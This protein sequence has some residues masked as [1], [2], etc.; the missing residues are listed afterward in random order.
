VTN[1]FHYGTPAEGDHF[2]GRTDELAALVGRMVDGIN[3]VV[4]SPRRYG[5]TSL[6]HAA[7]AR[8]ARRRP[9]GAAL[10]V[11]VLRATSLAALAGM[12][13]AGA[14]RL[15]GARWHRLRQAVPEFARRLRVQPAISFDPAGQP[16]FGFDAGLTALDA[17]AVIAD[18]YAL[19]AEEVERRPAALVLDEFQAVTRLGTGMPDVFKALADEHPSVSLV[20]AGSK[21]HL[22]EALVIEAHAPLYGMAQ[23]LT[24]GPLPEAEMIGFLRERAASGAR[25]F[26]EGAA[27]YL[28]DVAGPVPNDIQ[29]LAY[30][31]YA[32]ADR[33]IE[34]AS[35]DAAMARAVEHEAVLFAEHLGRLSPGQAR[36]MV[37]LASGP[38]A[39]PFGA[40]FAR[41]VGLASASSVRKA[42]QPLLA[43]E[44]VVEGPAGLAV[45]DPFFAAW[46]RGAP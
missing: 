31:A 26:A 22:M 35:V 9:A 39:E 40:A 1:P 20:L 10:E 28:V 43:E 18:V 33:H 36:V 46:L 12:L 2:T 45:A 34:V 11:N 23:R 44:E 25:P 24:L 17:E 30:E 32:G 27:E 41:Q 5:K 37:A 4:L 19:L 38:P 29:H 21:R 14:F 6:L 15:P 8:L 3:V 16:R 7:R 42:L 13:T